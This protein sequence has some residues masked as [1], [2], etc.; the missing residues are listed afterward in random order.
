MRLQVSYMY[1]EISAGPEKVCTLNHYSF[2]APKVLTRPSK[3]PHPE[4]EEK[5]GHWLSFQ[6]LI[7]VFF[8]NINDTL[9]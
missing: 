7:H 9:P 8:K 3:G 5:I 1:T 6:H 2:N 4:K